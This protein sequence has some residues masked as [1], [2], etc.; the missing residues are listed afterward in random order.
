MTNT[1]PA[2]DDA[3]KEMKVSADAVEAVPEPGETTQQEKD[4]VIQL[5]K[6]RFTNADNYKRAHLARMMRMYRLYRGYRDAVNY[7]YGTNIMPS[8]GFEVVETIKP[9]LASANIS[10]NLSPTKKSYVNDAK[11]QDW[12][13]LIDYDLSVLGGELTSFDDLKIEWINEMLILG[14]GV[15][16]LFWNGDENGG[17][18]LEIVDSFLLYV[19]PR[20]KKRLLDS[21]Y[22][23]K[24]SWK[25]KAL[26]V[27]E[28]KDRGEYSL[29]DP[30]ELEKIE[31]KP[32]VLD[33]RT[34]RTNLNTLRMSMIN[35]G[36]TRGQATDA[37]AGQTSVDKNSTEK[38]VEIWECWDHVENKL[39]TIFNRDT[40][41]R[42]DANPYMDVRNG[43]MFID[44]PNISLNHE[45]YAMSILE[46][47]ETTIYE[48]ADS[49]NQ[50]M[51]AIV[52]TLDPIRKIKKGKGYKSSDFKHA[53][54]AIWELDQVDDVRVETGP[55]ISNDWIEKD[56]LLRNEIQS[57][58]ALSEYV[59]GIPQSSTEPMGKVGLLLTQ[60]NIRF[61]LLVRQ[62]EIA[63]TDMVNA[64]IQ[65]NK[66]FLGQ[67]K[68]FRITGTKTEFKEFG[69]DAKNI[70]L[71]ARVD[72]DSKPEKSPDQ[73]AKEVVE[74]YEIL[75]TNDTPAQG[76]TPEEIN[77]FKKRKRA[78]QQMMVEKFG[79]DKYMDEIIGPL[80][81]TPPVAPNPQPEQ[82]VAS[83]GQI[84]PENTPPQGGI[85]ANPP[86]EQ[87]APPEPVPLMQPE[88][89]VQ[90]AP[91][92]GLLAKL[93]SKFT[94]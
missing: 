39:V 54:G 75:V 46:P 41:V 34:E 15:G 6:K 4:K 85:T 58:L 73:Q 51:D 72:I 3:I 55:S 23:I 12:N 18:M 27:K 36:V 7:A 91:E 81:E 11:L 5:W 65:M 68:E 78:M 57:A 66:V 48:I 28:E 31:D 38:A 50:A 93:L 59:R 17:P 56:T 47:I 87:I 43:R 79:L 89:T 70:E 26:I 22:E 83:Q 92:Q 8:I 64:M 86:I 24:Q 52:F 60:T 13:A 40:L 29:Y 90:G 32:I 14:N 49:R 37:G 80:I 1:P 44:L 84:P 82:K 71:D 35:D 30:V 94:K 25:D 10:I 2:S 45:Y 77:Q 53:P 62:M 61:S 19:D 20:S 76:S 9:R 42:N 69:E 67:K 33:P 63:F 88:G 74:L 21:R 16:Q